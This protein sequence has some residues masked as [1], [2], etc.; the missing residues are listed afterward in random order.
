MP[1]HAHSKS[2]KR[3]AKELKKSLRE[4]LPR[5]AL[6]QIAEAEAADMM[7]PMGVASG[8]H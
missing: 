3:R 1:D 6:G 8:S 4:D 5:W 2:A 7:K